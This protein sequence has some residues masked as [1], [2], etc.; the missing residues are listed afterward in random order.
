VSIE[1]KQARGSLCKFIDV[2]SRAFKRISDFFAIRI[3]RKTFND[4]DGFGS[5][6]CNTHHTSVDTRADMLVADSRLG[7]QRELYRL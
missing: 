5:I 6:R 7:Q 1:S 3:R 4:H 2:L